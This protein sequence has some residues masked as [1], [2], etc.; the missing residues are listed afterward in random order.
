MPNSSLAA[1]LLLKYPDAAASLQIS[2]RQLSGLV[3]QGVIP[4]VRI[5]RSVRFDPKDLA[6]FIESQKTAGGRP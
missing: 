6:A 2:E 1:T 5:K 3:R 4:V